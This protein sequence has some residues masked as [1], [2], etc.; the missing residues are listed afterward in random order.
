M[1][2]PDTVV[3]PVR[4]EIGV[5]VF[6]AKDIPRG[7]IVW[8]R[9]PLDQVVA[10]AQLAGYPALGRAQLERYVYR[11]DAGRLI[12]CWDNAR[13]MNHSCRPSNLITPFGFSIAP[14]TTLRRKRRSTA[15][16]GCR[17]AGGA[18]GRRTWRRFRP[19]GSG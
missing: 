6:A 11:D 9:D 5:G 10:E 8:A 17:S 2:H 13:F 7:T 4:R 18:W 15:T 3:R 19:T 12:L 1:T 14:P 16:A